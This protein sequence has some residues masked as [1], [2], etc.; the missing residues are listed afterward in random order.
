ML[1][2]LKTQEHLIINKNN[3]YLNIHRLKENKFL[4]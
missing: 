3:I 4:E 2:L 1:S